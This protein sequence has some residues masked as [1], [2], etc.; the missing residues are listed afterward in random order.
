ML[1]CISRTFGHGDAGTHIHAAV[2]RLERWQGTQRVATDI[3]EDTCILIFCRHLLEGGI[4]IAVSASLTELRRTSGEV[5]GKLESLSWLYAECLSHIVGIQLSRARQ[6]SGETSCDRIS[7]REDAF[8]LFLCERLS[9]LHHEDFLAVVCQ[10]LHLVD[11][12]RVLVDLEDRHPL[13]RHLTHI[14]ISDTASH[15]AQSALFAEGECG[16]TIFFRHLLYFRLLLEQ[17]HILAACVSRQEHPVGALI[18]AV[19]RI[20]R[21]W[22]ADRHGCAGMR[23]ACYDTQEHREFEF[24][25]HLERIRHHVV[26]LL[27]S[28]WFKNRHKCELTIET[29]VLLVL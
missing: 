12:K 11:W 8:Q 9:V 6:S 20:L 1:S 21:F 14:V 13:R 7:G 27:L 28:G 5:L 19:E 23:E 29:G 18:V 25:R 3:S 26:R 17:A 24:L 16:T 10:G 22:L 4:Y 2:D 15:D